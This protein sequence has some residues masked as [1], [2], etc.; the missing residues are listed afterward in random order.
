MCFYLAT[1]GKGNS[2][3]NIFSKWESFPPPLRKTES[4]LM[5]KML[6]IY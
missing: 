6:D 4:S 1:G 5:K 2:W 3:V